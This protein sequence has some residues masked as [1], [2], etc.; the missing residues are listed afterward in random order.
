MNT[1]KSR[2]KQI[3]IMKFKKYIIIFKHKTIIHVQKDITLWLLDWT[4][5]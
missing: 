5:K 4:S 1:Y 2:E 3:L